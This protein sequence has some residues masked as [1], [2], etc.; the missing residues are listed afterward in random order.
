MRPLRSTLFLVALSFSV[1]ASAQDSSAVQHEF[2]FNTTLLLK[3]VFNL[4]NNTFPMLPYDLTYKRIHGA[5][6]WRFGLGVD[7]D[8]QNV[9]T[10]TS[11]SGTTT[12]PDPIGPTYSR[13][14]LVS[15]REGWEK[16][17]DLD[18]RFTAWLG[19]D[20]VEAYGN[21]SA[22][23]ISVFNN[24]PGSYFYSRTTISGNTIEGGLGPV[25]GIQFMLTKRLSLFT[26][27]PLYAVF[28]YEQKKTENYQNQYNGF[29]YEASL[30]K[31]TVTT[32]KLN[33]SFTMPVTLYL[34]LKF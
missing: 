13:D 17:F 23:T 18:K 5:H 4:S 2:G 20:V 10:S 21:N 12:G 1:A 25:A 28:H 22:Q 24:L 32:S 29:E 34:A 8:L 6:A 7:V 33:F 15:L 30:D 16:R 9:A 26:E 14:G 11:G 19:L 31:E 27:A 3:Q